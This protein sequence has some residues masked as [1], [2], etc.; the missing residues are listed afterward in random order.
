MAWTDDVETALIAA[1]IR[2]VPYEEYALGNGYA[3]PS[4]VTLRGGAG[5]PTATSSRDQA[6]LEVV[7]DSDV[8]VGEQLRHRKAAIEVVQPLV[9]CWLVQ[10][11]QPQLR[12]ADDETSHV[13]YPLLLQENT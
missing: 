6:I 13:A 3:S 2:I 4:F 5:V 9:A 11:Q 1:G 8:R 12:A 10:I 7:V